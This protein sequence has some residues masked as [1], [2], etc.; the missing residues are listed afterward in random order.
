MRLLLEQPL[1]GVEKLLT[2]LIF[3]SFGIKHQKEKK[4]RKT[5][6]L[7]P[8][9]LGYPPNRHHL[10]QQPYYHRQQHQDRHHHHLHRRRRRRTSLPSLGDGW[11]KCGA[12]IWCSSSRTTWSMPKSYKGQASTALAAHP[13]HH[14]LNPC[15]RG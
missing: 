14:P 13:P 3:S 6:E 4:R 1:H 15:W 12:S 9:I 2:P 8:H 5:N 11:S 10:H 7:T